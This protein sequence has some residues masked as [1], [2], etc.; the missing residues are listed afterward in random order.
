AVFEAFFNGALSF[1]ERT[2]N[3]E[4]GEELQA[5]VED[6]AKILGAQAVNTTGMVK[7]IKLLDESSAEV[8]YDVLLSGAPALRDGYGLA[9]LVDDKWKVSRITL[10]DLLRLAGQQPREC[11]DVAED[12]GG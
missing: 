9:V 7:T 10:C 12:A 1:E 8:T 11:Q 3:L 6:Q 2:A 5:L 4:D